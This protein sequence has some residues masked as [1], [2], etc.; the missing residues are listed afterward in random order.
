MDGAPSDR[1]IALVDDLL[2]LPAETEWVEFKFNNT[3]PERMA[4]TA[5]ALSNA[6]RLADQHFAYILWGIRNEDHEIELLPVSWT[7]R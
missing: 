6:A 1:L 4:R 5:S 3:E 7:P 2:R